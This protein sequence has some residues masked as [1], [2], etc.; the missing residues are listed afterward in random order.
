MLSPFLFAIVL[1]VVYGA[2]M[3]GLLFVILY[4]DNLVLMAESMEE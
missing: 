4:A 1:D 3:D 2:V